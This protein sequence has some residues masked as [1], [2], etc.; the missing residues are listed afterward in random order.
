MAVKKRNRKT[1]Q[2]SSKS[3]GSSHPSAGQSKSA[4]PYK[5]KIKDVKGTN[6]TVKP[7]VLKD[8]TKIGSAGERHGSSKPPLNYTSI[9]KNIFK[10]GKSTLSPLLIA[11]R[12]EELGKGSDI[13]PAELASI[14]KKTDPPVIKK[15]DPPVK[16]EDKE[17][18]AKTSSTSFKEEF[19]K[20]RAAGK[21][22]FT[23]NG[24]SYSTATKD[25]VK[26]S[27]SKNLREHEN[28]KQGKKATSFGTAF[29]AAKKEG[30]KTFSFN[31]KSY[32]TKTK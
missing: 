15:T 31:G 25:D 29:A 10:I 18:P 2:K 32:S 9:L 27:G 30:A 6:R 24:K 12:S 8:G 7:K 20:N 5:R 11:L 17:E 4:T 22:N 13:V 21:P 23:W 14:I 3:V 19:A 26:K 16:S 28:K 1:V